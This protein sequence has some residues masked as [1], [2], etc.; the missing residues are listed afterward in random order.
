MLLRFFKGTGPGV[1]LVIVVTLLAVWFRPFIQLEGHFTLYFDLSPM[2]LYGLISSL[3]GTNPVPGII[4]SLLL[5][6]L[7]SVLIVNLNSTIFFINERTFL[8]AFIYILLSGLIPQFQLLNPAI[9]SSFFLMIA[10]RRIMAAYRIQ[11]TAYSFFDAGIL[12]GTGTLFYANLI[13][14]GLLIIIG[15]ALMRTGNLKEIAISIIGLLTPFIMTIGIYY[16]LDKDLNELLSLFVYNLF[17]KLTTYDFSRLMIVTIIYLGFVLIVSISYLLIVMN[18]KKIQARKTFF[19]LI[20]VFL[21]SG[22]AYVFLPS[23]SVEI[24]WITGIP[25]SYFLTHYFIFSRKKLIPEILFSVFFILII[26][27]QALYLI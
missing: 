18:T 7:M 15:I 3:I 21:I 22:L 1:I 16:V 26:T 14:F 11:G 12:I 24:I 8:P 10:I 4:L 17:G 9:F 5:V 2:P 20:W 19:L 13:W 23:V 6:S 27:I 25:V